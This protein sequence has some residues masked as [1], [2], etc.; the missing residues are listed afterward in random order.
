MISAVVNFFRQIAGAFGVAVF[1]LFMA[2]ETSDTSWRDFSVALV[3]TA[4]ALLLCARGFRR[5]SAPEPAGN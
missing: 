2:N 4:C 5:R 3:V 1:G